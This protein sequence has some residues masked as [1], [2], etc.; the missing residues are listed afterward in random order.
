MLLFTETLMKKLNIAVDGL[1]IFNGKVKKWTKNG[2]IRFIF[3]KQSVL[4]KE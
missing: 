2:D 1:T 3:I 4:I